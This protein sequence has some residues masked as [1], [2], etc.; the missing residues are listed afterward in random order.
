MRDIQYCKAN[1]WCIDSILE[2]LSDCT[3]FLDVRL[4]AVMEDDR[5]GIGILTPCDLCNVEVEIKSTGQVIGFECNKYLAESGDEL[6][7]FAVQSETD[8]FFINILDNNSKK[9]EIFRDD[10]STEFNKENLE[11]GLQS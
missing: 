7:S 4:E 1:G 2:Y 3:G 10:K 8:Q 11:S 6:F 5:V 9:F